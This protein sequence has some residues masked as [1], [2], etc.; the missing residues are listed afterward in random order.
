MI[1]LFAGIVFNGKKSRFYYSNMNNSL[2]LFLP[3]KPQYSHLSRWHDAF[4]Y[5]PYKL[6]YID[7][8]MKQIVCAYIYILYSGW[9]TQSNQMDSPCSSIEVELGFVRYSVFKP[10]KNT[11]TKK[12]TYINSAKQWKLDKRKADCDWAFKKN[13]TLCCDR[14]WACVWESANGIKQKCFTHDNAHGLKSSFW[15][16]NTLNR[17]HGIMVSIQTEMKW[18]LV[19]LPQWP[20][21]KRAPSFYKYQLTASTAPVQ[22]IRSLA[23]CVKQSLIVGSL[24]LYRA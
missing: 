17:L 8:K 20:F 2:F 5:L 14:M 16:E 9:S 10:T 23:H 7:T 11:A 6:Q 12:C 4:I 19:S 15:M 3:Y 18:W 1:S 22:K 13:A 21:W 24:F